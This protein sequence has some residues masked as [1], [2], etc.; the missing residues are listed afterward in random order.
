MD[1]AAYITPDQAQKIIYTY[2]RQ[3]Y[4]LPDP[5]SKIITAQSGH[6]TNGWTSNV[7]LKDNNLFGYGYDGSGNYTFYPYGIQ[8]SVDDLVG[9]LD[10]HL[11]G[12]ET[13]T[14][15][16]DYAQAIR[17]KGYYTDSEVNYSNGISRWIN[18]NLQIAAG[19]SVVA[20]VGIGVLVYLMISRK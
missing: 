14:V 2:L 15:P 12:Y 17:S 8:D 5:I 10:R 13:I 18:N 19:L 11:P 1:Q 4:G 20:I 16:D 6:E 3:T 7:Y 9:W